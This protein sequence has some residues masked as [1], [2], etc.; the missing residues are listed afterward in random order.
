MIVRRKVTIEG[1][2]E[3]LSRRKLAAPAAP[4]A[5]GPPGTAGANGATWYSGSGAPESGL[6]LNGDF[7]LRTS[8][9]DVYK[10]VAGAWGVLLNIKGATGGTGGTGPAGEQGLTGTG[11]INCRLA[12]AA[13]L[14]AY[15]RTGN[16][17][18]ANANGALPSIDGKAGA[19][20]QFVLLKDGKAGA[21]NGP[22]K[23]GSPGSVGSKWWMERIPSFDTSAEAVPGSIITVAEGEQNG[24]VE[25]ALL[26]TGAI[27]LNTTALTFGYAGAW[28]NAAIA[29]GWA[30][31]SGGTAF[32]PGYR[33]GR[34][35][36]VHLR[37]L[38]SRASGSNALVFTL[39]ANDPSQSRSQLASV[40]LTSKSR[41]A[42]K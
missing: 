40:L 26:T 37:G 7:Y 1:V 12:T 4:L 16:K 19:E 41:Q 32:S 14:P 2:L 23:I 25:F 17:I 24:G 29:S 21:D 18:E 31:A 33:K 3:R 6:G 15:T 27:T 8:N 39:R 9:Y 22:Y 13:E 28:I 34:D 11:T 36:K 38:A 35:G 10:K 20:N 5:G 30:D 42:A